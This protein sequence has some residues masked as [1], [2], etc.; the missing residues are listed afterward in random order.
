MINITE[1]SREYL[2]RIF[3][4]E[5]ESVDMSMDYIYGKSQKIIKLAK[6]LGMYHLA[7]QFEDALRIENQN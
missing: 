1:S 6:E 2:E 5:F 7:E 3:K 4:K